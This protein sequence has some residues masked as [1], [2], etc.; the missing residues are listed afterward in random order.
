MP[1]RGWNR[2][3][4]G[5]CGVTAAPVGLPFPLVVLVGPTD[6]WPPEHAPR[7]SATARQAAIMSLSIISL[8]LLAEQRRPV[9]NPLAPCSLF[10][11]VGYALRE[12]GGKP[13]PRR[14]ECEK[15]REIAGRSARRPRR[16]P[17]RQSGS[18]ARG[19][20]CCSFP[21][22]ANHW[23]NVARPTTAFPTAGR[24]PPDAGSRA[25]NSV[26]LVGFTGARGA[27]SGSICGQWCV[28]ARG[29]VARSGRGDFRRAGRGCRS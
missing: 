27:L 28:G 2:A 23:G 11:S 7:K 5:A 21:R 6:P 26:Q 15:Y 17:T 4:V 9:A 12:K 13:L 22:V 29:V 20:S 25:G 3:A 19:Q 8:V 10:S 14:N 24:D 1:C 18:P 16:C